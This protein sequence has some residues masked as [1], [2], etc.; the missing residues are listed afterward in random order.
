M[1]DPVFAA[2]EFWSA[3]AAAS[4]PGA[5]ATVASAIGLDATGELAE[6]G[7]SDGAA[8][9]E[10]EGAIETG[11]DLALGVGVAGAVAEAEGDLAGASAVVREAAFSGAGATALEDLGEAAGAW[12][13]PR[14]AEA[15]RRKARARAGYIFGIWRLGRGEDLLVCPFTRFIYRVWTWGARFGGGTWGKDL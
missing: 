5:G 13:S 12:A 2:P 3:T 15:T 7:V 4:G 14:V 1:K 9:G 8:A 10:V 6:A 11:G